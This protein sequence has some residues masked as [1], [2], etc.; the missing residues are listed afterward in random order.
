[1]V[2]QMTI[3][4][5]DAEKASLFSN[6]CYNVEP[7]DW[8][9]IQLLPTS[10]PSWVENL[11]QAKDS[12]VSTIEGLHRD[13]RIQMGILEQMLSMYRELITV[14]RKSIL[15]A[16]GHGPLYY[17]CLKAVI[18]TRENPINLLPLFKYPWS[19][20]VTMNRLQMGRTPSKWHHIAIPALSDSL[21]LHPDEEYWCLYSLLHGFDGNGKE[22]VSGCV[23][24]VFIP[25]QFENL[26]LTSQRISIPR[27]Y[28]RTYIHSYSKLASKI[29]HDPS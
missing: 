28:S 10:A 29:T 8:L 2:A 7:K 14:Q 15:F 4:F 25:H 11:F 19:T 16:D 13:V 21:N 24:E 23:V 12:L 18:D 6:R 9:P 3:R 22:P 26:Q 1:M 5:T 17:A 27:S 20:F